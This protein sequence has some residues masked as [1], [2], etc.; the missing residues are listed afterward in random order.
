MIAIAIPLAILLPVLSI[1]FPA[2][3]AVLTAVFKG[4]STAIVWLLKGLVF[5]ICLPFKGIKAL[6][7]K[8]KDGKY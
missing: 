6:I 7:E 2:F 1:F 8:I 5:L 4:I 3:R